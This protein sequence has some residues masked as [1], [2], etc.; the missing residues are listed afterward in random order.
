MS[1]TPTHDST[2]D[3]TRRATTDSPRL[4][5]AFELGWTQWKLG[6][7]AGLNGKPWRRTIPA[8]DL[9]A[10][11][12]AIAKARRRFE[13]PDGVPIFSCYEAGRDGFWLHRCLSEA[14]VI[15]HA[16]NS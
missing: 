11:R 4:Y 14:G 7:A 12:E 9:V 2:K 5:L 16:A 8:R 1:A 15:P 10:L 3:S 6:F 13:L